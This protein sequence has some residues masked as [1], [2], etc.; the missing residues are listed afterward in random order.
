MGFFGI[1]C[2]AMWCVCVCV[3]VFWYECDFVEPHSLD[4]VVGCVMIVAL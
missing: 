3:C 1:L 2:D 4:P